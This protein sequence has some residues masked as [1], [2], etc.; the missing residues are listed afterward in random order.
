MTLPPEVGRPVE[1]VERAVEIVDYLKREGPASTAD[2]VAELDCVKSTAHRHLKTLEA[3][4]LVVQEDGEYRV[5]MRF[6]D[7]GIEAR[8]RNDL[9]E[10]AKPRV[11]DLAAETEEKIWCAVEE[12]GRS[13]HVYGARGKRSVRTYARVGHRNYLHQHA[14]GKAILAH[15][16]ADR[17]DGIIERH[18][19]PARTPH[20]VTDPEVLRAELEETR[21]RGYALN[22]EES[23]E[24]L[25][26]VG[27]PITDEEGLAIG[28]ISISGPA[29]RLDG[30]RLRVELPDLLAGAVNEISINL[31]HA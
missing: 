29:N 22:L 23:V 24:G 27:A 14:A 26:A 15:L 21:E 16:P 10:E 19:L 13:I 30:D 31:A 12:H 28:A 2:V 1:T 5:G 20:T 3:N 9:F 4:S 8:N 18:G 25:H 6:L 11:D 7:Y 17:I